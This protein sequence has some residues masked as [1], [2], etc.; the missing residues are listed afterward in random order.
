MKRY[1]QSRGFGR[2]TLLAT[3]ALGPGSRRRPAARLRRAGAGQPA[4]GDAQQLH[5]G[6]RRAGAA[7]RHRGKGKTP[8]P[9][10]LRRRDFGVEPAPARAALNFA[11]DYTS[12]P[13]ATI[14][15]SP[16]TA[17]PLEAALS[18]ACSPN[19]TRRTIRTNT[20]SRIPAAPWCPPA[21]AVGEKFG[22]DGLH[23]L[24]AVTLG[25]DIGPRMTISFGAVEFRN[26]SH[27]ATHAIAGLF[28]AAA[29]AGSLA[30]LTAQQMRWLLDYSAQQ[31][32]GIGAWTRDTAHTRNPSSSPAC[33]RAAA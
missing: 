32:S 22:S 16:M 13:T 24:R 20:R 27:K 21:L 26:T 18:T 6:C 17:N 1:G 7:R 4:D 12:D 29:A 15:A 23:F 33:R 28:G 11:R 14:V 5:G 10:Y 30:R 2:R 3:A 25:Y 9:R 8:H 19:P 31:S